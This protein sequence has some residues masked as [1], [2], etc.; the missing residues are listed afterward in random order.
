MN[1][2]SNKIGGGEGADGCIEGIVR[3][4]RELGVVAK[5]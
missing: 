2:L 1:T 3:C 5:R 4:H